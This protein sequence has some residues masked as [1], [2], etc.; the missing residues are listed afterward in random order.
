MDNLAVYIFN[1]KSSCPCATTHLFTFQTE[2]PL[3]FTRECM[4]EKRSVKTV[5]IETGLFKQP[6]KSSHGLFVF[7]S[8]LTFDSVYAAM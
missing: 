7:Q 6:L 8:C 4:Y 5:D 1:N 2:M 3:T